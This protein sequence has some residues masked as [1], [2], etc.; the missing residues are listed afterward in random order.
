MQTFLP[1]RIWIESAQQLDRQ[2]L[3]KQ[4]VEA[5]QLLT[6]I[7]EGGRWATHPAAVMWSRYPR[8]LAYY[9]FTICHEWK[10]RG[11]KDTLHDK[12]DKYLGKSMSCKVP[13]WMG[14]EAFHAAHR[15]NLK[16]KD[17]SHYQYREPLNLEYIWPGAR[18]QDGFRIGVANG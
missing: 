17:P 7:T 2:R 11:Y 8:A 9:G 12:F 15:S 5:W 10:R 13:W 16:R 6:A 4:R 3:G 1:S 18:P 14:M